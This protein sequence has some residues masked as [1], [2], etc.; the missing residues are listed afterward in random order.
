MPVDNLPFAAAMALDP[1]DVEVL[2]PACS[3][4]GWFTLR[5]AS[6]WTLATFR[7]CS[8]RLRRHRRSRVEEMAEKFSGKALYVAGLEHAIRAVCEYASRGLVCAKDI[9]R[10]F[11]EER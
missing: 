1:S 8:F 4:G 10:E 2:N 7:T 9:E 6:G 11:L 3:V 5:E